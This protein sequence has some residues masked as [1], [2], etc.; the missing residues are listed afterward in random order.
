MIEVFRAHACRYPLMEPRDWYKLI[1]QSEF[2]GG[3][4]VADAEAARARFMKEWEEAGPAEPHEVLEESVGGGLCRIHLRPAKREGV[5][6]EAVF[7]AF[8]ES[9][10]AYRGSDSGMRRKALMLEGFLAEGGL[11]C[12][13]G[14]FRAYMG[15]IAESGFP[16]VSHSDAYRAGYRPSYRIIGSGSSFR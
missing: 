12:S 9:A 8:L 5:R 16:M 10:S 6:P 11:A 7:D 3:H 1:Y 15:A 14:G 2:G 13:L 4:L